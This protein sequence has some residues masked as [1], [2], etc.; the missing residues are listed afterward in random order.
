MDKY[1]PK[2]NG[3]VEFCNW[4]AKD[5][6]CKLRDAMEE[7]NKEYNDQTCAKSHLVIPTKFKTLH[8]ERYNGKTCARSNLMMYFR[9]IDAH[10]END[11]LSIHCF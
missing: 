11:K 4:E 8:F 1:R 10:V 2:L 6:P 5:T 7:L 3:L 9:K